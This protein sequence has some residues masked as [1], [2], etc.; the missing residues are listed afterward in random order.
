MNDDTVSLLGSRNVAKARMVRGYA[1]QRRDIGDGGHNAGRRLAA[2]GKMRDTIFDEDAVRG[3]LRIRVKGCKGQ[4]LHCG[5]TI[6]GP[7]VS[8]SLDENGAINKRLRQIV[9]CVRVITETKTA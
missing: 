7:E 2:L 4:Q 8:G 3:L 6:P 1:G 9:L 5:G